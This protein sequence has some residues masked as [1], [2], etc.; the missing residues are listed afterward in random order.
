[1]KDD[2]Y[3]FLAAYQSFEEIPEDLRTTFGESVFVAFSKKFSGSL[4]F[5]RIRLRFPVHQSPRS[6]LAL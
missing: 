3:L 6:I 2:T 1:M 5:M 4:E